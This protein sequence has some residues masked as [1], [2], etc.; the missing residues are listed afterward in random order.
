MLKLLAL[1]I[2]QQILTT[3]YKIVQTFNI[4]IFDL[5]F[6]VFYYQFDH[7]LNFSFHLFEL[8]LQLPLLSFRQ[9]M[10]FQILRSHLQ[11]FTYK[12]FIL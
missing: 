9:F 12:G 11:Y 8:Y 5:P 3:N 7:G 2:F 4:F 6:D 10:I 1:L